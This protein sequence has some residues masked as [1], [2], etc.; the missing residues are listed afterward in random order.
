MARQYGVDPAERRRLFAD[1]TDVVGPRGLRTDTDSMV[2]ESEEETGRFGVAP[3]GVVSP[4][5][6]DEVAGVV[7][8]ARRHGVPLVP[9]G[10]RTSLVGGS[11]PCASDELVVSTRRM[12]RVVDIDAR[13]GR[14][15]VEAGVTLS[16][17]DA[18]L[19]GTDW[20][21]AVDFA[22]R[23]VATVGGTV[24]TNAGGPRVFRHGTTRD[25][26]NGI[27]AVFGTGDPVVHLRGL[28][29]DNTGYD[30]AALLCGSE[31]TLGVICTVGLRLI[32][33]R[34]VVVGAAIGVDGLEEATQLAWSIAR[35]I[36]AAEEVELASRAAC[37]LVAER[38][39]RSVPVPGEW[40]LF[41]R[42]AGRSGRDTDA[43]LVD[44]GET[45]G[46]HRT[47]MVVAEG[48]AV[49]ALLELRHGITGALGARRPV[50]KYDVSL[51][52]DSLPGALEEIDR[53]VRDLDQ[54]ARTWVFGHVCDHNMHV[55]VTDTTAASSALDEAVLGTVI[56]NGGSISA[57]HGVG[58][59]KTEFLARNRDAG[60]LAVMRH[61]KAALD[62]DGILNPGVMMT[63]PRPDR[64][65]HR[66]K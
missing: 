44:L 24:A 43:A 66:G 64:A 26:I 6:I 38:S 8:V 13:S 25:Q 31:G 14:I 61:L 20:R 10:G 27:A 39:A 49:S 46:A 41:V 62:P 47:S 18:A 32:E 52:S 7:A 2:A 48:A 5:G 30:L 12:D 65:T 9:Q 50:H 23:D 17:V 3:L 36:A 1:M 35:G 21:Y 11:V 60:S 59:A 54:T 51:P 53:R 56:S 34:D 58:V 37:N 55:N 16:A 19:R 28:R 29:K 22:A 63:D 40:L 33:R 57:E 4:S 42:L 45:V 15:Q